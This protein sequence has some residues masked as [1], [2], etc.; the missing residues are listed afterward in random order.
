MLY[1]KV[2][3]NERNQCL[4]RN[5]HTSKIIDM[6]QFFVC[7]FIVYHVKNIIE[8]IIFICCMMLKIVYTHYFTSIFSKTCLFTFDI[9][10][11]HL[12]KT[13]TLLQPSRVF[14]VLCHVRL[15]CVF[16]LSGSIDVSEV[17]NNFPLVLHGPVSIHQI[18]IHVFS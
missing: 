3:P 5:Y 2:L 4:Y 17:C 15:N 10:T 13:R 1:T 6:S 8:K 12:T 9:N 16:L 14:D 18:I 11:H 7:N